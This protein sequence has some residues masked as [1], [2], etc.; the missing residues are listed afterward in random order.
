MLILEDQFKWFQT[1]KAL[2]SQMHTRCIRH[3]AQNLRLVRFTAY[4]RIVRSHRLF[5]AING[6]AVRARRWTRCIVITRSKS[7]RSSDDK[8][9]GQAGIG[10]VA[11]GRYGAFL[12]REG[13]SPS[14]PSTSFIP[15]RHTVTKTPRGFDI[16]PRFLLV[17]ISSDKWRIFLSNFFQKFQFFS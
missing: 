7:R 12:Q 2:Y 16:P 9:Q 8:S 1:F 6:P 5:F 15:R 10:C 17:T 4:R 11:I 14:S 3:D 13:R